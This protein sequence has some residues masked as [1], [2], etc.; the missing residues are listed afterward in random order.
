VHLVIDQPIEASA[1]EAQSAF[2]DPVFY[3]T[4]GQLEGISAPIVV[5]SSVAGDRAE[6]RLRYSFSGELSGPVRRI[7]DP[8]K[9]TWVQVTEVDLSGR[10]SDVRMVPDNYANLLK[11]SGW[12]ELRD[13]APGRCVQ[14]FEADLR[15]GVPL[16]GGLAERAI[17]SS[18]RKNL[19][20]TAR[21]VAEYLRS[22]EGRQ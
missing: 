6:L 14:H 17:A 12:Y 18:I 3:Q 19:V 7:L 22:A 9:L 8:A 16:L 21:L 15:V 2:L 1:E 4:L 11:F 13:A 5:S 20:E 10:R